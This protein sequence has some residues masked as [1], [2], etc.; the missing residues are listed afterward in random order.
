MLNSIQLNIMKLVAKDAIFT[1]LAG[2]CLYYRKN[3]EILK[4]LLGLGLVRTVDGMC[5]NKKYFIVTQA[6]QEVLDN[7]K[8]APPK[9]AA[10]AE[11]QDAVAVGD[12]IPEANDA[13]KSN[14]SAKSA[15]KQT[16]KNRE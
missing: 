16:P 14:K 13:G 6:G 3:R 7:A 5:C 15:R 9:P 12:S 4:Q 1:D 11:Q 2:G 10:K 8:A